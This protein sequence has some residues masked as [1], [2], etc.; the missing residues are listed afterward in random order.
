MM[1]V[2]A[3]AALA[4]LAGSVACSSTPTSPNIITGTSAVVAGYIAQFATV[5]PPAISGAQHGGSVSVAP[6]GPSVTPTG[7]TLAVQGGA[8]VVNLQATGPFQHAF[9]SIANNGQ[10]IPTNGFYEI[11]LP[12]AV[13][14]VQVLVTFATTWPTGVANTSFNLQF[15]VTDANGL[16]GAPGAITLTATASVAGSLPSVFA[17]YNPNPAAFLGGTACTLSLQ[18]GCLWEF[19][20]ILQEVNGVGVVNG[21][22]NETFTFGTTSITGTLSIQIPAHGTA[23]I[24]RNLSCGTS[25]IACATP[26]ELAGGTYTYTITGTDTN[27]NAFSFTGPLLTLSG[28]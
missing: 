4:A 17:T 11:D 19:D 15:Q 23:T 25:G 13:T 14:N 3:V 1:R 12:A 20:V 9:V 7:P 24:T 28:R 22:M 2:R 27:G 18:Q 21:V 5:G 8:V 10:P 16:G 26:A 6:G